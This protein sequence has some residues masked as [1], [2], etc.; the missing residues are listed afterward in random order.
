MCSGFWVAFVGVRVE[1]YFVHTGLGLRVKGFIKCYSVARALWGFMRVSTLGQ[2]FRILVLGCFMFQGSEFG[3]KV[4]LAS[5]KWLPR[6]WS[7]SGHIWVAIRPPHWEAP[8]YSP[9]VEHGSVTSQSLQYL[10]LCSAVPSAPQCGVGC[11]LCAQSTQRKEVPATK[12]SCFE[13]FKAI[14]TQLAQRVG[15]KQHLV[16][17]ALNL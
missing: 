3:F 11:V 4:V 10:G 2:C 12:W 17:W 7:S 9:A 1:L 8:P 15:R 14:Q 5:R 13:V 6:L 16:A